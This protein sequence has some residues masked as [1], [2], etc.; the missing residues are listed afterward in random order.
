MKRLMILTVLGWALLLALASPASAAGYPAA[1]PPACAACAPAAAPLPQAAISYV[2]QTQ[3]VPEVQYVPQV[4]YRAETVFQP[5]LSFAPAV[6]PPAAAPTACAPYTIQQAAFAPSRGY[7]QRSVS[8]APTYSVARAPVLKAQAFASVGHGY[9]SVGRTPRLSVARAQAVANVNVNVGGAAFAPAGGF[10]SARGGR[11]VA[12]SPGF[13]GG[14]RFNGGFAG[15]GTNVAA[16][17]VAVSAAPGQ[18]VDVR[19]GGLRGV[20]FGA[21]VR[22]R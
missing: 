6:Y 8:F 16:R 10:A 2:P 18:A 19:T 14:A 22:V 12:G 5:Q 20:L 21:R 13:V 9:R 17:N 7:V 1:A 3:F 11:F 4:T 15:G